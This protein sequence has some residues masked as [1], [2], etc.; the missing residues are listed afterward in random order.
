MNKT[1]ISAIAG[2]AAILVLSGLGMAT[3]APKPP[4]PTPTPSATATTASPTPTPTATAAAP[5]TLGYEIVE[6]TFRPTGPTDRYTPTGEG[7]E[8]P[9]DI[10]TFPTT[11]AVA[12]CPVG[13]K[14]VGGALLAGG[15]Y[16]KPGES[17]AHSD[18]EW[19]VNLY[20]PDAPNDGEL[21][22]A[23]FRDTEP[24]VK[25]QGICVNA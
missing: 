24:L 13:K 20:D 12:K 1:R 7:A 5:Y 25:V 18:T 14:I 8:P 22:G 17:Y 19:G 4:S 16:A 9:Y 21:T 23:G 2:A 15:A 10:Y 3:A 11:K 6:A